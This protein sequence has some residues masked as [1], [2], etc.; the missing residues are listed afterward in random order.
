[1]Y[2]RCLIEPRRTMPRT[3]QAFVAAIAVIA[4]GCAT[5][6]P[7]ERQAKLDG[8]VLYGLVNADPTAYVTS[9]RAKSVIARQSCVRYADDFC[10]SPDEFDFVT[11][12]VSNTYWGGLR[13]IGTF[14]PKREAVR[15]SD[16]IVVRFRRGGAGQFIEVASRGETPD[17]RWDG[18]GPSRALTAAGVVCGSYSWQTYRSVLYD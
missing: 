18:G 11:A 16:I 8:T 9:D 17:C 7:E 1:M 10:R 12:L 3:K 4:T 14:V 2:D 5:P 6:L 15:K 13:S